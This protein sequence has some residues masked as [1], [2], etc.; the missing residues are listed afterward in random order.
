MSDYRLDKI[1]GFDTGLE[2]L[3]ADPVSADPLFPFRLF[4]YH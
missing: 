4:G 1:A 2:E 3:F